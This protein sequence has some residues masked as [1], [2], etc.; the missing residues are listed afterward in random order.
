MNKTP[1]KITVLAKKGGV[2]KS[3][4]SVLLYEA[5]LQAKQNVRLH[6]WDSQGTS[7]RALGFIHKQDTPLP[8]TDEPLDVLIYDTPPNFDHAATKT[9]AREA[10]VILIL[11]TPSPA[12]VWEAEEA[13]R[14]AREHNPAAPIRIVFNK[15]R[16]GTVL[17]RLVKTSAQQIPGVPLKTDL[18]YRECYQH[19]LA[20]GWRALD[21]KARD[22]VLTLAVAIMTMK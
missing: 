16:R 1:K 22:E 4:L 7:S 15:V 13:V 5:L 6:D 17:S 20:E 10:D 21:K 18:S 9:A 8:F 12:D 3:T 14:F 19:S 11:T 2:G